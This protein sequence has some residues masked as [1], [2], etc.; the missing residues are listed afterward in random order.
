MF[1]AP[2]G[3]TPHVMPS[4]FFFFFTYDW[5]SQI[6][7]LNTTLTQIQKNDPNNSEL[8]LSELRI[9]TRP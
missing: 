6:A 7:K 5:S 9:K 1:A 3:R 8:D 4:P 2:G